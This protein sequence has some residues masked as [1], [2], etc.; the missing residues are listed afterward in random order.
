MMEGRQTVHPE[1]NKGLGMAENSL[2]LRPDHDKE[3]D[4]GDVIAAFRGLHGI[5]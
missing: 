2:I 4:P 1:S 3:F 5:L